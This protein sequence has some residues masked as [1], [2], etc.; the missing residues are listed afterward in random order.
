MEY[1]SDL[2]LGSMSGSFV[3]NDM[4]ERLVS[5]VKISRKPKQQAL[6]LLPHKKRLVIRKMVANTRYSVITSEHVARMMHIGLDKAKSLL[7]VTMQKGVRTAVHPIHRR[8]RMGHIDLN[9]DRL[10]GKWYVDWIPAKRKL[11][12]VGLTISDQINFSTQ[13]QRNLRPD[14]DSSRKSDPDR[15]LGYLF[16]VS[17][18]PYVYP[19]I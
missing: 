13:L 11:I 3:A 14:L 5:T 15:L 19:S 1:K 6:K 2:V 9:R 8:Y 16:R 4:Y 17:Y 12:T 7:K 10:R 18:G